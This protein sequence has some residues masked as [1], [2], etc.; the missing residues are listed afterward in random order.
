MA[1]ER[2]RGRRGRLFVSL[3][4]TGKTVDDVSVNL[5]PMKRQ[6]R[7]LETLVGTLVPGC[8]AA[9]AGSLLAYLAREPRR[10]RVAF[11]LGLEALEQAGRL[12]GWRGL[13]GGRPL[14]RLTV[15]ERVRLLEAIRAGGGPLS[16]MVRWAAY[17]TYLHHYRDGAR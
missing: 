2:L 17:L 12:P 3:V 10:L 16:A 15:E 9:L 1:S 7:L 13:S 6:A 5:S 8:D 14:S 4:S 11:A